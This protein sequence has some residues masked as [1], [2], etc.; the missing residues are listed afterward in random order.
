MSKTIVVYFSHAGENYF[1]GTIKSI[2]VGNA[3]KLAQAIAQAL[4]AQAFEIVPT[5]P[6]PSNYRACVDRAREELAAGARPEVAALPNISEASTVILGYPNWC[7]TIPMPV[8]TVLQALDWNG[9]TIAPFCSNEG[10]GMGSSE[11]DIRKL[12]PGATVVRGL[13]VFGGKTDESLDAA[14]AWAKRAQH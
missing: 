11:A 5:N 10:S 7:G 6:Y 9:K 1:S 14:I 3:A 8:A 13:S 12:A 4:D 2:P